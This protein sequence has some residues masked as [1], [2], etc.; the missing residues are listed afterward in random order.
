MSVFSLVCLCAIIMTYHKFV[1]NHMHGLW[2]TTNNH[3]YVYTADLSV[4]K[5]RRNWGSPQACDGLHGPL[6]PLSSLIVIVSSIL[7]GL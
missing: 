6:I 4:S 5:S 1:N 7:Q 2:V 3:I